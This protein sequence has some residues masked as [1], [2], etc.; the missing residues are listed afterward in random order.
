M[1]RAVT[2]DLDGVYFTEASF[3]TFKRNL[4]KT[5]TEQKIVN[6]VL[7]K[8]DQILQFKKGELSENQYWDYVRLSLGCTLTNPQIFQLLAASYEVD[9]DV[10]ASV[11]KARS[12]GLKTCICTNNF[13][14]RINSLNTKFN[15]LA[16][17]DIQVFSYEV[18]ATKPDPKIFQ[19]LITQSGCLPQEIFY[20]D[21]KEPNVL[22]AQSLGLNAV[23]Y[24]D[25]PQFLVALSSLGVNL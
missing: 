18:G 2:F 6:H 11:K 21:D 25:F 16:D 17:F 7:F 23:I 3:Q 12:L 9:S 24:R 5:I 20:A 14:T 22:T 1:I 8:S 19:A 15:F 10:V 13:P 4:P